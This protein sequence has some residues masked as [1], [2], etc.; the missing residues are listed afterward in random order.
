MEGTDCDA[1]NSEQLQCPSCAYTLS[2]TL[3][4]SEDRLL[5]VPVRK[6]EASHLN[7]HDNVHAVNLIISLFHGRGRGSAAA[8]VARTHYS[9]AALSLGDFDFLV[10][11]SYVG[12]NEPRVSFLQSNR[13]ERGGHG[14]Q[15]LYYSMYSKYPNNISTQLI[16]ASSGLEVSKP[17]STLPLWSSPTHGSISRLGHP[18]S[19]CVRFRT[20]SSFVIVVLELQGQI[21]YVVSSVRDCCAMG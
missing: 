9:A 14:T 8:C 6:E 17:T 16:Y 21:E 20:T 10:H 11:L 12:S 4:V 15:P 18:L 19:R 5:L 3:K 7:F 13:T 2:V 1:T